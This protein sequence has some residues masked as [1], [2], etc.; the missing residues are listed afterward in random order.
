MMR[1]QFV[2]QTLL[3]ARQPVPARQIA[4]RY[5]VC[6]AT[7]YRDIKS[8]AALGVE[9]R[10]TFGR[11]AQGFTIVRCTCPLCGRHVK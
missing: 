2:M 11:E 1:L 6:E 9:T 5:E 4:E 7:I 8:L 10:M 3:R